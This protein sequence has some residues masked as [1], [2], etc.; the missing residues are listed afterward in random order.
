MVVGLVT[1]TAGCNTTDVERLGLRA[2]IT[3]QAKLTVSLWQGSWIAALAVGA[4]VWGLILWAVVFHRKRGDRI[5]YQVST[6]SSRS[7][8]SACCSTSRRATR[9]RSTRCRRI[10]R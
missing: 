2:P 5:P 1:L 9:T 4:A 8:W 3:A 7:S 6:R 10:R